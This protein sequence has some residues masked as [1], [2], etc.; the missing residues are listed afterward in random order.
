MSRQ[1]FILEFEYQRYLIPAGADIAGIANLL[2]GLRRLSMRVE[3][4]HTTYELGPKV[5]CAVGSVEANK[6][7]VRQN[8]S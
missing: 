7:N 6:I 5:Q 4:G 3:E 1:A 8:P 2:A